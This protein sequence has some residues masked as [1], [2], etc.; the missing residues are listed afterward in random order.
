MKVNSL[1]KFNIP[2]KNNNK[3]RFDIPMNFVLQKIKE[4]GYI[5]KLVKG[6]RSI[7]KVDYTC[8]L[9]TSPS[10]RDA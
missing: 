9:Y 10:P 5:K 8:L 6:Y 7:S 1:T 2:C 3:L 4:K